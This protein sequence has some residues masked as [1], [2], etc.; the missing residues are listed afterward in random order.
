MQRGMRHASIFD[1]F[2]GILSRWK[3]QFW[4]LR[5]VTHP[6]EKFFLMLLCI[7]IVYM[8]IFAI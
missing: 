4:D 6:S 8:H 3:R 7:S 5:E 1:S 2:C